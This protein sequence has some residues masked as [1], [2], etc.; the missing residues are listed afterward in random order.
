[1][2]HVY[3]TVN[4][5][6]VYCVGSLLARLNK[7]NDTRNEFRILGIHTYVNCWQINSNK[8]MGVR[9]YQKTITKFIRNTMV[10]KRTKN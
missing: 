7:Q 1:M 8:V 9:V 2:L 5:I 4:Y 10:V 6:F 3:N